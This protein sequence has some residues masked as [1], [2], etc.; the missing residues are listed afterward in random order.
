MPVKNGAQAVQELKVFYEEVNRTQ[1]L[2][3]IREPHYII[4]TAFKTPT[5]EKHLRSLGVQQCYEKPIEKDQLVEIL[6][7]TID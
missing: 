5:F 7:A 3:K 2:I 4:L 6:L 1:G